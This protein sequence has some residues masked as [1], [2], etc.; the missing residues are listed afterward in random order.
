MSNRLDNLRQN[1]AKNFAV[2]GTITPS[3]PLEF[4]LYH[5]A[6][7]WSRLLGF[8]RH[9]SPSIQSCIDGDLGICVKVGSEF[10]DQLIDPESP[11]YQTWREYIRRTNSALDGNLP[12]LDDLETAHH[13]FTECLAGLNYD[14]WE[15]KSPPTKPTP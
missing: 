14:P 12:T 2:R 10:T 3:D 6:R 7:F 15:R 11:I 4:H 13:L 5:L 9:S 1:Y 8:C